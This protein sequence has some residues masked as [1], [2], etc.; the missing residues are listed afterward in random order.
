ME[1]ARGARG[2]KRKR[3]G[4]TSDFITDD[5]LVDGTATFGQRMMVLGIITLF[6]SLFLIF[7]G[8]GLMVM[9]DNPLAILFL[10][11]PGIWLFNFAREAWQGHQEAKKRVAARHPMANQPLALSG[12]APLHERSESSQEQGRR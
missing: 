2:S 1:E 4:S 11:I 12:S 9:K 10:I 6:I 5:S 3:L 7:V 8:T